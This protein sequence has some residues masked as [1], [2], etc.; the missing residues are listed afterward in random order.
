MTTCRGPE[1]GFGDV[2][3]TGNSVGARVVRAGGRHPRCL[4]IARKAG[5]TQ[6]QTEL[7]RF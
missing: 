7:P 4:G 5:L 6:H 2:D 1:V 3:P